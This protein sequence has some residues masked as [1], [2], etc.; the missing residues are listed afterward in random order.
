VSEGAFFAPALFSLTLLL[1]MF[2]SHFSA[3]KCVAIGSGARVS[4]AILFGLS[5]ILTE[6][7]F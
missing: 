2:M 6:R 4:L 3:E 5:V 7:L 1:F